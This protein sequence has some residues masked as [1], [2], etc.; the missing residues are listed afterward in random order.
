[1]P[2]TITEKILAAH[3][4]RETVSPGELIQVEVDLALANDITAPSAIGVFYDLGAPEVFDREKIALV[5]DHFV[6]NKDI[7]SAQQVK[8]SRE[9]AQRHRIKHFF[10][11]GE[12]GIEHVILPEKGLVSPG[13]LVI[14]ADSHT[15]TYGALGAFSKGVGSTDLGAILATGKTWLK[16][17]AT[18]KLVYEGR[19]P[20]WVGGKDLILYTLGLIGVAGAVYCSLE[21]TGEVIE[22][23]PMPQRFTM[24]NMA[25]EAGAKN[26]IFE[27][28]E[29]TKAYMEG[30][31][32]RP[33]D[34][35]RS[36][37]EAS[38][39]QEIRIM[40]DDME[41][42]V[43][44]PHSPDHVRPISEL[45]SVPLDQVFLGSCTNGRLEDLREAAGLLEGQEVAKGTRFIV[46]PGSQSIYKE[47]IKEG[48]IETF[49]DAGA[50]IGPPC[51]GPCLGG[52]MGVLAEGERALS[53]SNR[54]FVGRMGHPKSEVYLAGPA[55]AAASAIMGRIASP[56]EL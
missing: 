6:P 45:D 10:E 50:V 40:V 1:M 19:L 13:D 9:F 52:H 24:A 25:V 5:P 44:L 34:F 12:T 43:A 53:T 48:I 41:P 51:C 17:P 11:L 49:L 35:L 37:P 29:I 39:D 55:V 54:N 47:A 15:C 4:G 22:R 28:D 42:Q 30:R 31:S 16:V 7:A 8:V 32:D 20:H 14:G 33:G 26:G 38:Y 27:P 56:E 3:A 36:D 23:L 18:I 46:I 2:M 21:F